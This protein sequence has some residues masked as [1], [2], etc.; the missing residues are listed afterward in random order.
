MTRTGRI[1]G[2]A[3][4]ALGIVSLIFVFSVAYRM[5]TLPS[6]Q[7]FSGPL[8][9]AGLGSATV[10]VFVRI[11]L[12][13]IMTLAGALIA[14]RGIHLYLGCGERVIHEHAETPPVV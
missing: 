10:V 2:M 14:S 9:A 4:F 12:L 6:P 8:T 7:L 13:F 1:V 11:A 5:F 3:I